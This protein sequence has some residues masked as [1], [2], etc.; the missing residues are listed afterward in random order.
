M[1]VLGL[2]FVVLAAIQVA[3]SAPVL[4][5]GLQ[6]CADNAESLTPNQMLSPCVGG[7]KPGNVMPGTRIGRPGKRSIPDDAPPNAQAGGSDKD[8][9]VQPNDDAQASSN[10]RQPSPPHSQ[11]R[12]P[13]LWKE[14]LW[15]PRGTV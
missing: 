14:F 2:C 12:P 8:S 3:L 10:I 4:R 13:L 5:R 11:L 9:P 15:R 7:K 6:K 1:R